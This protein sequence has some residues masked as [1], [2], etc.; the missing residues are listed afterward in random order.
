VKATPGQAVTRSAAEEFPETASRILAARLPG[1]DSYF[2]VY[3]GD[4]EQPAAAAQFVR[5]K[6][7]QLDFAGVDPRGKVVL[8]AGSGFGMTLV[9][10]GLLGAASLLGLEIRDKMVRTCEAYLPLLSDDLR[11]RLDIR[12]GDVASMPYPDS[13]VDLVL[14]NEAISHYRDVDGFLAEA[15][16]ILRPGGTLLI[17]DGNNA[18]NPLLRRRTYDVW[19]AFEQG[20]A[21]IAVHGHPIGEEF[22]PFVQVRERIVSEAFPELERADR[23]TLAVRT[24]GLTAP[25][26]VEAARRYVAKGKLPASVYRRGQ[27]AVDPVSTQVM[28]RIFNPYALGREIARRGFR[29]VVRGYWGGASGRSAVRTAN[30]TLA[31]LSPLTMVTARAFRIAATKDRARSTGSAS[32][33]PGRISR[34]RNAC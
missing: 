34:R 18:L 15:T 6:L 3:D 31:R 5:H 12:Q 9:L 1:Y 2:Y 11:N 23:E 22:G 33:P 32:G 30:A 13:A 4:L 7:D 14:S 16:R 24:A 21:G 28:E 10:Y 29:V 27:L 25:E 19:E 20:P 26:V 8:D 17:S